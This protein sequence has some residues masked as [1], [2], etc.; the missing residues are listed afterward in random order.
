MTIESVAEAYNGKSVFLTGATGFVGKVMLEKLL[1]SCPGLE[2]VY[3]LIREKQDQNANQRL[4]KVF[5]EQLFSRLREHNPSALDKIVPI[6]GDIS[7]PNLGLKPSDEQL[8]IDKVSIVFHVAATIKFNE[9]LETVMNVNVAGTARV[10]SL[11]RRLRNPQA[12]VYMSTAYSYTDKYI[13]NEIIYPAPASLKEVKKLI[14]IGI[15]DDQIKELLKGRPNTYTFT[16]A[17]AEN[18]VADNH[19]DIPAVIVRPAIVSPSESEP[20]V[21]WVD[22]W[23]GGTALMTSIAKGLIRVILGQPHYNID[24]IPVDYVSNL[25]IVS[26]AKCRSSDEVQVYNC[27]TSGENPLTLGKLTHL[28]L[29]YTRL[30]KF[31]DL[32]MPTLMFTKYR[33]LLILITLLLQTIPAYICDVIY[34]LMG[35]NSRFV[36]MLS[37]AVF[38][39]DTLEYF[40]SRTWDIRAPKARELYASLSAADKEQFAFD[41]CSIDWDLYIPK[42]CS[43]IKNFLLKS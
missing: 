42:Y 3:I 43:G 38:V 27:C 22:N 24:F 8:L 31:N 5:S 4:K 6:V 34:M 23:F 37:K 25:T 33:W 26:A 12:F 15:N 9:P 1:Y 11:S 13:V 21:G 18:L 36:K 20:L 39:R 41:P 7:E 17:L 16:K 10:L 29:N 28:V 19:G 2:T 14:E 32:P 35:K 40:T 30:N